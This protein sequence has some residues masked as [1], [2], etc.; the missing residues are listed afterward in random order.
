MVVSS[1]TDL[2]FPTPGHQGHGHRII[3]NHKLRI[4]SIIL[5]PSPTAEHRGYMW[6]YYSSEALD[7]D[8]N[9]VCGSWRVPALWYLDKDDDGEW[10]VKG[11][12]EGP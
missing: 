3:Q 5:N 2:R 4:W 12:K 6:V 10:Y 11:I 9:V 7:K 1:I 8:G